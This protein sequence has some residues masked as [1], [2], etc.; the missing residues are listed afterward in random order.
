MAS[1]FKVNPALRR[2]FETSVPGE[3]P[4]TLAGTTS[5]IFLMLLLVTAS[6]VATWYAALTISEALVY[7]AMIGGLVVGLILALV[8]TF[9]PKTAPV[10]APL[11][12][13]AEGLAVGG[14]SLLFESIYPGIVGKAVLATFAVAFAMWFVYSTGLV[15]VTKRFRAAVSA[16]ILAIL[17]LYAVNLLMMLFGANIPFMTGSSTVAIVVQFVIVIV[18]SLSLVID[19]DFISQQIRAG[20][21]KKMEWIAAFGIIVTIVWLY[22]EMIDLLY[23]LAGRE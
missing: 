15:K 1:R 13:L 14:I 21:P 9:K 19:F 3:R 23:R 11:Y 20:A 5:K 2:G 7:P 12:A 18:A 10:L 8:I 22:I 4:M 17:I 6:A 16:A